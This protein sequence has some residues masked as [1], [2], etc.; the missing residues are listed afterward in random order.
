[1]AV[2]LSVT[3][4]VTGCAS[5]GSTGTMRMYVDTFDVVW[6]AALAAVGS[7][8]ARRDFDS[9]ST[10]VILA[11]IGLPEAGGRVQLEIEV[12]ATSRDPVMSSGTDVTVAATIADG[13]EPDPDLTAA[14]RQ[15]EA[16][17]LDLLDAHLN[18]MRTGGRRP[19]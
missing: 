6:N 17:Y 3:L 8:G 4:V 16:R 18:E 13:R 2:L 10:G 14:L 5:T 19:F 7:L 11:S 9:R 1:M 15:I 12:R